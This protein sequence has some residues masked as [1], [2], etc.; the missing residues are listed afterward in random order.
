MAAPAI[1][2]KKQAAPAEEAKP[3]EKGLS[4]DA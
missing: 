4:N 1:D 3:E 2:L